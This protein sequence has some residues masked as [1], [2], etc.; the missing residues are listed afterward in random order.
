MGKVIQGLTATLTVFTTGLQFLDFIVK[1][2]IKSFNKYGSIMSNFLG[3]AFTT[4]GGVIKKFSAQAQLAI[5]KIPL[6]GRALDANRIKKDLKNA[7]KQLVEGAKKIKEGLEA[8]ETDD[9][10]D[11]TVAERFKEYQEGEA[12]I[13]AEKK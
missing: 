1:E 9:G 2:G 3:G 6:I 8:L 10:G 7:E 11:R 5:S 12:L 13:S 4:L